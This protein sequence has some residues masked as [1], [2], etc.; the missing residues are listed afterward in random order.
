MRT[1]WKN[2]CIYIC[3]SESSFLSNN[4]V[5][6]VY[7]T[8]D[9]VRLFIHNQDMQY[10]KIKVVVFKLQLALLWLFNRNLSYLWK[11]V[12]YCL[13]AWNWIRCCSRT[14]FIWAEFVHMHFIILPKMQCYYNMNYSTKNGHQ[15]TIDL[16]K[17]IDTYHGHNYYTSSAN[18][19]QLIK[20]WNLFDH[21]RDNKFSL[22]LNWNILHRLEKEWK[23]FLTVFSSFL[24]F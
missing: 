10:L 3:G 15:E 19:F 4:E 22:K 8:H 20:T 24:E 23:T 16:I 9:I 6:K 11:D 12:W 21:F 1:K 13:L 18:Q 14:A 7:A 5:N 2:E 17:L